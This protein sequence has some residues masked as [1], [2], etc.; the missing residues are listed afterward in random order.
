[1]NMAYV[2]YISSSFFVAIDFN[3]TSV[4]WKVLA[5]KPS[6]VQEL[7]LGEGAAA[8]DWTTET[9]WPEIEGSLKLAW[10]PAKFAVGSTKT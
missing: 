8:S 4:A 1:M 9:M 2:S 6:E 5:R 10:G 3:R 7:A